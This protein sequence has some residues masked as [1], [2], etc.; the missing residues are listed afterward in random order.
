MGADDNSK[1]DFLKKAGNIA[2]GAAAIAASPAIANASE[3]TEL[4]PLAGQTALITKQSLRSSNPIK[5]TSSN[6]AVEVTY[7]D[8]IKKV[9]MIASRHFFNTSRDGS[10]WKIEPWFILPISKIPE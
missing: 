5:I 7:L 9:D 6:E 10:N 1:R 3:T 8:Q 2:L 4:K